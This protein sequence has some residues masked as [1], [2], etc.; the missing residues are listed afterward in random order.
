VKREKETLYRYELSK[1]RETEMHE[2]R[3]YP[4]PYEK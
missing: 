2:K 1:E 3:L 4:D